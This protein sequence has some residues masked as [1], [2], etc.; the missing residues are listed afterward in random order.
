MISS[1]D[2]EAKTHRIES[3][4]FTNSELIKEVNSLK[5]TLLFACFFTFVFFFFWA[6]MSINF[7]EQM[8]STR[9]FQS[10]AVS[11]GLAN[12]DNGFEWNDIHKV[13]NNEVRREVNE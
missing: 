5:R 10:Q 8:T 4:E 11:L 12:M 13:K 7:L 2:E 6:T 3:L 1:Y 9:K